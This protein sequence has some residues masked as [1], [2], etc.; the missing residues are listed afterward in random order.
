LTKTYNHLAGFNTILSEHINLR[1]KVNHIGYN[2]P[3][4]YIR[5]QQ[6]AQE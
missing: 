4:F 3:S 1:S 6:N 2:L 5:K